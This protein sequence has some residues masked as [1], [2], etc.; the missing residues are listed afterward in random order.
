MKPWRKRLGASI[1]AAA[2]S[3][4]LLLAG[5]EGT[6]SRNQVDATVEEL[7]GKKEV[8]RM[9]EMKENLEQ[10]QTQQADRMKQL[11]NSD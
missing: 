10:I 5:C 3:A 1:A 2:L 11:Q 8:D 6:E 4:L 9:A 7:F